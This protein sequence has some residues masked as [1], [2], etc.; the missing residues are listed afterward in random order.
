M[1][2]AE[3]TKTQRAAARSQAQQAVAGQIR[4]T[5]MA[6][7]LRI[8]NRVVTRYYEEELR[9]F[10]VRITQI[11]LLVVIAGSESMS[12]T[13]LSKILQLEKS[14][15]TRDVA[16]LLRN[17]WVTQSMGEN[18]RARVLR[19]TPV[20]MDVIESVQEG[21]NRAQARTEQLLGAEGVNL[22]EQLANRVWSEALGE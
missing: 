11:N 5:C 3:T 7:R 20:G 6:A 9:E 17:G 15:V 2:R 16:H 22:V 8:L 12:P 13:R 1:A 21:W 4:Q 18:E 10:G 19:I 14:T